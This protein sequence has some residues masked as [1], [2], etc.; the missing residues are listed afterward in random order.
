MDWKA[1]LKDVKEDER[2]RELGY[3]VEEKPPREEPEEEEPTT[4]PYSRYHLLANNLFKKTRIAPSRNHYLIEHGD[5]PNLG[6]NWGNGVSIH[7]NE[8]TKLFN[9]TTLQQPEPDQNS[10]FITEL[11]QEELPDIVAPDIELFRQNQ[12]G[13]ILYKSLKQIDESINPISFLEFLDVYLEL[14]ENEVRNGKFLKLNIDTHLTEGSKRRKK[15]EA[16]GSQKIQLKKLPVDVQDLLEFNDVVLPKLVEI[17]EDN[18][19]ITDNRILPR[20][21]RKYKSHMSKDVNAQ[22]L[23]PILA[24]IMR[25]ESLVGKVAFD[26]TL[27]EETENEIRNT[28][29]RTIGSRTFYSYLLEAHTKAYPS[30]GIKSLLTRKKGDEGNEKERFIIEERQK[31]LVLNLDNAVRRNKNTAAFQEQMQI[32]WREFGEVIELKEDADASEMYDILFGEDEIPE[33]ET[34]TMG[35]II[36][37]AKGSREKTLR[38]YGREL[39]QQGASTE[40]E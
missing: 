24:R 23:F 29:E 33:I 1:I 28:L 9:R 31:D 35:L 15:R 8:M 19:Y 10:E 30:K 20:F 11:L 40:E 21:T 38:N 37:S 26:D 7:K 4:Y 39:E 6:D 18:L 32:N 12:V 34:E 2:L 25:G 27:I 22:N 14:I 3:P 16:L 13:E 5:L 17:I 36:D